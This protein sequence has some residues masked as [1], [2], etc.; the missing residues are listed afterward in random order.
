MCK[1]NSK[2]VS[3]LF[4]LA[5]KIYYRKKIPYQNILHKKFWFLFKDVLPLDLRMM[6]TLKILLF[7][8]YFR[9][10]L[11]CKYVCEILL[12]VFNKTVYIITR[13]KNLFF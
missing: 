1:K 13:K 4:I 9:L 2:R 11:I 5:F 8:E 7:L 10:I 3:L 12:L 6:L